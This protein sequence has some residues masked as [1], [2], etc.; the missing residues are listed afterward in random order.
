MRTPRIP[1]ALAACACLVALVAPAACSS[2]IGLPSAGGVQEYAP[3]SQQTKRVYT[4]PEGPVADDQPEGIVEGFF[5]AMPAGVQSDGY[6]V[7]REFLTPAASSGWKGDTSAVVYDGT[8]VFTRKASAQTGSPEGGGIVVEAELSVIGTLDSHGLYTPSDA[9]QST[10]MTFTM[11]KSDG[12][13]R[14]SRL[15]DGVAVSSAD[16]DQVFRQV[17]VYRLDASGSR[18][19]PDVRWLSWRNWRTLA[20]RETLEN[21]SSWLSGAVR[22]VNDANAT[23][24]VDS[25]PLDNGT[26][27]IQLS[28][29]FLRLG[30]DERALL[31]RLIRLTLGDGVASSRIE[32]TCEGNDYSDIDGSVDLVDQQPSVG[33]YTLTDGRVVSLGSS[34]PL[35]VGET[36]YESVDGFVFSKS[37]GAVLRDDGVVACL[38]ADASPCGVMFDG[39]RMSFIAAGTDGEVWAVD[40]SGHS[41]YVSRGGEERHLSVPWLGD[42]A[43]R[44]VTVSPEGARLA[45]AVDDGVLLT[46]VAR[47]GDLTPAG[48]SDKATAVSLQRG[49]TMLTFYN[50]L[51]LVYVTEPEENE[52]GTVQRA[53][54]QIAPGPPEDQRLPSGA[55]VVALASGQ[56][57]LYRRLAVLDG[58][59]TVRSVS[60]SLDGSWS[61]ADSQVTA[62]GEQ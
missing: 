16:F 32:V 40:A 60:G 53:F 34:S 3:V 33:L 27:R 43:I 44:A 57:A 4:N 29:D 46:G 52:S 49:V 35:R 17:S 13:W 9:S 31:V 2:P 23:L 20:V 14:I 36:G 58:G 15:D 25:V 24:A 51:N 19:V 12:Q 39:T 54:R 55:T 30:S 56:V 5:N 28:A 62:L 10:V 59:G 26:P 6:R 22:D 61:I 11:A 45:V 1:R 21:G 42:R 37:G 18:L 50:D 41:L 48:L 7:A 47:D 8:P 38:K